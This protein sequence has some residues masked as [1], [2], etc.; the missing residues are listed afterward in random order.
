[1]PSST[2]CATLQ[3]YFEGVDNARAEAERKWG[4]GRLEMLVSDELRARFRR[5][6][7]TWSE[8]YQA[9]WSA[10][11][12]TRDQ[13]E[14]VTTKAGAMQRAWAALDAAAEEAGH[15]PVA[16]FVW[17]VQLAT[18]EVAALVQTNAEASRVIAEGRYLV[19]YTVQE[20][21]NVIDALPAALQMAKVHFPGAKFLGAGDRSW[22]KDGDE[23]PFGNAVA[24]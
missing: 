23:I 18:G 8:A 19:V 10:D 6:C 17:E 5:Q 24:A 7:V 22:V 3:A 1:M 13:L 12:L 14:R 4:C 11:M 21:G 9:A 16:P 2:D 15:R 20:V